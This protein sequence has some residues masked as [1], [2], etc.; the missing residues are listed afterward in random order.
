MASPFDPEREVQVHIQHLRSPSLT[1]IQSTA[2]NLGLLRF[3]RIQSLTTPSDLARWLLCHISQLFFVPSDFFAMTLQM[4]DYFLAVL[5][6]NVTELLGPL[7][8]LGGC[9]RF[10]SWSCCCCFLQVSRRQENA[11]DIKTQVP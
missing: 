9:A 1:P 3:L 2:R 8:L 7:T 10:N 6:T 4:L 11:P 5:G